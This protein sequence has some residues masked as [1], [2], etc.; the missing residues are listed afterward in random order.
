MSA[1]PTIHATIYGYA[2][3]LGSYAVPCAAVF[4]VR[5]DSDDLWTVTASDVPLDALRLLRGA[6]GP[7]VDQFT[8]ELTDHAGCP[9]SARGFI[10]R[11][12]PQEAG[13]RLSG[14]DLSFVFKGRL[15]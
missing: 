13:Y 5:D 11:S 8:L 4:A 12:A 6:I 15:E 7:S 9:H 14:D 10:P 3:R 2:L 1:R